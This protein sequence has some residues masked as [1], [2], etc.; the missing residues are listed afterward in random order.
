VQI[1][2]RLFALARQLAGSDA[3]TLELPPAATVRDLRVGMAKCC[4]ALAAIMPHLLIAVN[5]EYSGDDVVLEQDADVA[6]IPPVSG[7]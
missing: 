5:S 3:I 4:P 6:C 1:R 7:G 2:I